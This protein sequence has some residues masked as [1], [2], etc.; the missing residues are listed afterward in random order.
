MI[1]VVAEAASSIVGSC[2]RPSPRFDAETR[3]DLLLGLG[4]MR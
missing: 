4:F 3:A 2:L 1:G